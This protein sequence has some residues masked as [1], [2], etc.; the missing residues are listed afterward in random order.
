M[1]FRPNKE[2]IILIGCI[3]SL[4]FVM[5]VIAWFGFDFDGKAALLFFL[6]LLPVCVNYGITH[7]RTIE[8]SSDGCHIRLLRYEKFYRWEDFQT[9][10]YEQYWG[11]LPPIERGSPYTTGAFFSRKKARQLSIHKPATR[12]MWSVFAFSKIYV[13]FINDEAEKSSAFPVYYATDEVAFR[14]KMLQWNVCMEDMSK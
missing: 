2:G 1:I 10:R 9:K 6:V 8:M 12:I 11:E 13:Y 5:A 14:E 7:G 4:P 3:L